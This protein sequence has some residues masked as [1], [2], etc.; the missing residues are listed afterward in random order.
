MPHT[1][2]RDQAGTQPRKKTCTD[3]QARGHHPTAQSDAA[4]NAGMPTLH[5]SPMFCKFT[6]ANAPMLSDSRTAERFVQE[7]ARF[8]SR[9]E[10]VWRLV[11][12]G[13]CP[14]GILA[15]TTVLRFAVSE[16][17]GV[18]RLLIPLLDSLLGAESALQGLGDQAFGLITWQVLRTHA[19]CLANSVCRHTRS[20]FLSHVR[21]LAV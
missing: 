21:C 19:H 12:A 15:L 8:P 2:G 17:G 13:K 7:L 5:R 4:A 20:V 16:P 9:N 6:A 3:V 11:D 14:E 1:H 18:A 10:L